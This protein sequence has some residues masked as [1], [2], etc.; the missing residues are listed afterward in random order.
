[1]EFGSKY[2]YMQGESDDEELSLEEGLEKASLDNL[3]KKD[4]EV[5]VHILSVEVKMRNTK[6]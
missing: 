2:V 4:E 6:G 5:S 3:K 1:M